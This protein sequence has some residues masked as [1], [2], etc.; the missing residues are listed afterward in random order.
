ML[1]DGDEKSKTQEQKVSIDKSKSAGTLILTNK[2][3]VLE[4]VVIEKHRLT[5]DKK[6]EAVLFSTSLTG[7][8]QVEVVKK[9]IGKPT[10]FKVVYSGKEIVFTVSDPNSWVDHVLKAKSEVGLVSSGIQQ[11]SMMQGQ[12]QMSSQGVN[13]GQGVT[14]NLGYPFQ[15]SQPVQTANT[16]EKTV[17]KIRCSNCKTLY[18]ETIGNCPNCGKAN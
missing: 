1:F 18:D 8:T 4:K 13:V 5:K 2:R 9:L 10:S 12:Q 14:V 17:V 16:T 6:I 7:I 11:Q 15:A 3:L